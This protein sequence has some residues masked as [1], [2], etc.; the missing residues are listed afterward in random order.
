MK[1]LTLVFSFVVLLS[2]IGCAPTLDDRFDTNLKEGWWREEY[3]EH[4]Y[5]VRGGNSTGYGSGITHDP[6]CKCLRFLRVRQ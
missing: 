4:S 6:D 2:M 3:N 1:I 5:I